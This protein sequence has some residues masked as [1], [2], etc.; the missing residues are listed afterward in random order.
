MAKDEI[1][2]LTLDRQSQSNTGHDDTAPDCLVDMVDQ[3]VETINNS[4]ELDKSAALNERLIK[5]LKTV[6]ESLKVEQERQN[7]QLSTL[8]KE[9]HAVNQKSALLKDELSKCERREEDRLEEIRY[10][11]GELER[12][13][14]R[15]DNQEAEIR[16]P[17]EEQI[18]DLSSQL[19][20]SSKE[21]NIYKQESD[22]LRGQLK[23]CE[24]KMD[25]FKDT[26]DGL[27]QELE[28]MKMAA[29]NTANYD[30]EIESL[31]K[32]N[33]AALDELAQVREQLA[34]AKRSAIS[35]EYLRNVIIS[36]LCTPSQRPHM[37]QVLSQLLQMT[38]DEVSRVNI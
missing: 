34:T 22:S 38:P 4:V 23:E 14:L 17:L 12:T 32:T 29:S 35:Q 9:L 27:T 13:Q 16:E 31:K 5:E 25:S 2:R 1:A 24:L 11:K 6:K 7:E 15:V 3:S 19:A 26:I 36:F 28:S 20:E 30:R 8:K 37:L 33:K 21:I 10:L 18:N